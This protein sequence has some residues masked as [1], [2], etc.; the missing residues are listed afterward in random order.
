[1]LW[2][3]GCRCCLT[4]SSVRFEYG[5]LFSV[6]IYQTWNK[7]VFTL[8]QCCWIGGILVLYWWYKTWY[9]VGTVVWW[10][11]DTIWP[12][13]GADATTRC[14]RIIDSP[15]FIQVVPESRVTC[16]FCYGWVLCNSNQGKGK[17]DKSVLWTLSNEEPG[18]IKLENDL[19]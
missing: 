1:M 4:Y 10:W 14:S 5:A 15:S 6:I 2:C 19:C 8:L 13:T 3:D 11:S 18:C 7:I 16:K 12:A 9:I 17:Y